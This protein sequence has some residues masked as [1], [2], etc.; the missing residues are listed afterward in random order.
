[1]RE[2]PRA[3]AARRAEQPGAEQFRAGNRRPSRRVYGPPADRRRWVRSRHAGSGCKRRGAREALSIIATSI[4]L[5]PKPRANSDFGFPLGPSSTGWRRAREP[6]SL[7]LLPVLPQ[8]LLAL[9]DGE[10]F[11]GTS[12]GMP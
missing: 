3:A 6:R 1:M 9:A 11:I 12:I 5:Q 7:C 4:R 2:P 10:T 8:A